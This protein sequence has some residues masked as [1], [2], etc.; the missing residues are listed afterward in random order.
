[1]KGVTRFLDLIYALVLSALLMPVLFWIAWTVWRKDGWP[2]FY[3]SE[4]MKG[5]ENPFL[6]IKFRTMRIVDHD[7]G[8]SGGDKA[9]RITATGAWLRQTRLDELPQLWNILR[10]DVGFVGPRPP[11]RR[12]V[13]MFPEIYSKVLA[14]R[15]GVTGLASLAFHRH[16]ENLLRDTGTPEETEQIYCSRCIPRKARLDLLYARHR[17]PCSDLRLMFATVFRSISMHRRRG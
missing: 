7:A 12:Y 2:I 10:G 17:T 5:M 6:L 15:P 11:L 14:E 16:E 1:M 4:R 13:E 8:V 9:G 3:S